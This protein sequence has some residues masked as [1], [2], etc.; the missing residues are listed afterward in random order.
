[1]LIINIFR[2]VSE[3]VPAMVLERE[4]LATSI[5]GHEIDPYVSYVTKYHC[6]THQHTFMYKTLKLGNIMQTVI[7]TGSFLRANGLSH[8]QM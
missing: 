6:I 7:K 2:I 4:V 8:L 5:G 1:M 3:G